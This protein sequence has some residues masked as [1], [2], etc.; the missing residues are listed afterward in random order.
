MDTLDWIKKE[1]LNK[2]LRYFIIYALPQNSDIADHKE[3]EFEYYNWSA[4]QNNKIR[5]GDMFIYLRPQRASEYDNKFYLFGAGK[6]GTI[7]KIDNVQRKATIE[8]PLLFPRYIFEDELVSFPWEFKKRG[9]S[10]QNFFVQYGITQIT[11]SDYIRLINFQNKGDDIFDED[12]EKIA[13]QCSKSIRAGNYSVDDR[14]GNTKVRGAAQK[15]F[16]NS[17]KSSYRWRCAIS[18]I[19][20]KDFLVA[21]H[22]IPWAEDKD[23]RL[24]PQNGICLSLLLD[25]AF[26]KG[27]ITFLDNGKM[28]ISEEAKKDPELYKQIVQYEGR[29]IDMNAKNHPNI[30]FLEWHRNNIFRK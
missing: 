10:W 16:A 17:V 2:E 22:I 23:N 13:I 15:A 3:V 7:E 9:T 14:I 21:S 18:G 28:I 19:S 6:F 24:N 29:S 30:A 4:K 27:Y 12:D 1:C 8:H 25:K 26:D 11:Q 5:V 20:Q